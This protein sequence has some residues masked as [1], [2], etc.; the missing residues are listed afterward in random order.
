MQISVYQENWEKT[1][2]KVLLIK[3]PWECNYTNAAEQL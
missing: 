2:K 3:I 1:T